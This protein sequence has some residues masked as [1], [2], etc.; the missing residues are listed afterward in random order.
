VLRR[1]PRVATCVV[2]SVVGVLIA[3]A[4]AFCADKIDAHI[5]VPRSYNADLEFKFD[6]N[7]Y[8][9]PISDETVEAFFKDNGFKTVNIL[10]EL[11]KKQLPRPFDFFVEGIDSQLRLVRFVSPVQTGWKSKG[12]Y[13][14]GLYS[15]PPAKHD[16]SFEE[17]VLTFVTKTLGCEVRDVHRDA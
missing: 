17:A 2:T 11:R 14:A 12:W 10:Q 7:G 8:A 16:R 4:W 6:C 15:R 13:S 3:T 1:S 5:G 9:Y